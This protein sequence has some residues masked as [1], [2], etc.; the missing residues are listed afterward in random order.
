MVFQAT[1]AQNLT[2]TMVLGTSVLE[3]LTKTMVLDTLRPLSRHAHSRDTP[4]LET[5]PLSRHAHSRDTPILETRPFSKH[6]HSRNTPILE[7]RPFSNRKGSACPPLNTYCPTQQVL[8]GSPIQHGTGSANHGNTR[9]LFSG[10]HTK[11]VLYAINPPQSKRSTTLRW[12]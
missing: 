9:T 12:L 10:V 5:R 6:A 3:N 8:G 11:E 1:L 7:T 4:T 2:K